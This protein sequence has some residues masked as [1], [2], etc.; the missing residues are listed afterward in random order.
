MLGPP[1]CHSV[2]RHHFPSQSNLPDH[3]PHIQ[4]GIWS[5]PSWVCSNRNVGNMGSPQGAGRGF[6]EGMRVHR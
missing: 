2:S 3:S 5:L 1:P 6:L 4:R